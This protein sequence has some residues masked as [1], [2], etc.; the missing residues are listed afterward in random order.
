[1]S[2]TVRLSLIALSFLYDANE[3][4][5]YVSLICLVVTGG[6]DS[7][8]HKATVTFWRRPCLFVVKIDSRPSYNAPVLLD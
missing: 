3:I 7:L 2:L 5:L 1:M 8:S 4:L 6:V